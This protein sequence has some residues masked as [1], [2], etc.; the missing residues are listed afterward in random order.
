MGEF[1][2]SLS[3]QDSSMK[4]KNLRWVEKKKFK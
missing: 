2:S 4:K 1:S 3:G